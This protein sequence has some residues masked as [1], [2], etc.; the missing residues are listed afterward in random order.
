MLIMLASVVIF[1][2]LTSFAPFYWCFL[3]GIW[4]CGFSSIGLGTV[5]YCWMMEILAGKPKTIFGCA[6]HLNFALWGLAVAG[7]AYLIPDWHK[8]ELVFSLPLLALFAT[9]WILPESPRY[10]LKK[11]SSRGSFN[12]S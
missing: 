4:F 8:M 7:I 3:V 1:G 5:L 11:S 10:T 9:Y 12:I 6:P 2:T